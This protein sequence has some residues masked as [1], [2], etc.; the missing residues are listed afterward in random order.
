MATDKVY[1]P[2]HMILTIFKIVHFLV[3][4]PLLTASIHLHQCH[5]IVDTGAQAPPS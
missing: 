4:R 5:V 1:S 3:P 2:D